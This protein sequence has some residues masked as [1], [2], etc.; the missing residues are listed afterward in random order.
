MPQRN[1]TRKLV[2]T[3]LFA[4]L[5]CIGGW[6]KIPM[7]PVP[8]TLQ[9]FFVLLSGLFLGAKYGCM[10]QGLYLTLG[11]MG[12]PVFAYGGGP[13]Y[14][15]Q[16]TFGYLVGFPIAAF[17]VG[18]LFQAMVTG[19]KNVSWFRFIIYNMIGVLIISLLGVGYMYL[20]LRILSG[21]DLGFGK[22]V[23]SGFLLFL[24]ADLIKIGAL[25]S[26]G[27]YLFR[28]RHFFSFP[29]W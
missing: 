13:M 6:I 22:A 3:A 23:M 11:L 17:V 15:L 26:I 7:F 24:P 8:V 25:S 5:T 27:M 18:Y 2:L 10:S 16:P 1:H 4:V 9:T 12:L 21:Q 19:E 28:H 20:N 14:I 29:D